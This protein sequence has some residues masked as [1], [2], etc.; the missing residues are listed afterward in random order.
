MTGGGSGR[1]AGAATTRGASAFGCVGNRESRPAAGHFGA[2]GEPSPLTRRRSIAARA[3]SLAS[4]RSSGA[5]AV[6][7][8][9]TGLGAAATGA[10][11][12]CRGL[13]RRRQ[14]D[15]DLFLL[16]RR[17][18]LARRAAR[19]ECS[20][21]RPA[22]RRTSRRAWHPPWRLPWPQPCFGLASVFSCGF[23]TTVGRSAAVFSMRDFSEM[24]LALTPA[25]GR[26]LTSR[27]SSRLTLASGADLA[28]ALPLPLIGGR[29]PQRPARSRRA[30]SRCSG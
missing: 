24:P 20:R 8:G 1:S 4:R 22:F 15:P 16:A 17:G 29:S 30:C 10:D 21:S 2:R 3:R 12:R 28:S 7:T 19:R 13:D 27:L 14:H 6:S 26:L 25:A 11:G 23:S 9:A 18:L 5:T